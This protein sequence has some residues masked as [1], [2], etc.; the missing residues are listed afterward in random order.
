M[1]ESSGLR[2]A[3]CT[4]G[5]KVNSYESAKMAKQLS[6]AG[7]AL[8]DFKDPA[9]VYIINTCTVTQVAAKKSRQMI[10]RARKLSP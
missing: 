10:H 1:A 4:M 9:D 2:A 3:I 5:C 7:F 6:E 8:V